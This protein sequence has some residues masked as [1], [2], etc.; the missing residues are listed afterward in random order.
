MKH[1]ES[2]F[3]IGAA[4][5]TSIRQLEQ[6]VR[7]IEDDIKEMKAERKRRQQD[8]D[9]FGRMYNQ[10]YR[11]G[12]VTPELDK[13]HDRKLDAFLWMDH[14]IRDRQNDLRDAVAA[15]EEHPNY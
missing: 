6:N 3:T 10:A 4:Q 11:T 2:Y 13:M 14:V 12:R 7:E 15:L 9:D 1:I 8:R 5:M